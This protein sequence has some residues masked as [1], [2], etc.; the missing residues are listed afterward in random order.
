M[1]AA[2]RDHLARLLGD[3]ADRMAVALDDA[4]AAGAAHPAPARTAEPTAGPP[5]PSGAT[6]VAR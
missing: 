2:D 6:L 5:A 3:L 4:G 1:P